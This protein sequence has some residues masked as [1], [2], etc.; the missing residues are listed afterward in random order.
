[1]S[2]DLKPYEFGVDPGERREPLDWTGLK[3]KPG[4]IYRLT[5]DFDVNGEIGPEATLTLP[6]EMLDNGLVCEGIT[7]KTNGNTVIAVKM[8][9]KLQ[10][11][12]DID[13]LVPNV[14]GKGLADTNRNDG[15]KT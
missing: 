6:Q 12:C 2:E 15:E 7:I 11:G 8:W 14:P 9:R 13:P 4:E 10:N 3:G 5:I 1:M